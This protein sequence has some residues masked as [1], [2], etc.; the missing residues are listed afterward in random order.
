MKKKVR[1]LTLNRETLCSL[2]DLRSAF[3]AG[4]LG[5]TLGR[6]GTLTCTTCEGGGGNPTNFASCGVC[7]NQCETGGACTVTCGACSDAC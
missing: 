7:S 5:C 3:G 4:S 2:E 6:R 1:K